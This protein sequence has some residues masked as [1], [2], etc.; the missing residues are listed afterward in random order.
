MYGA[1]KCSSGSLGCISVYF[2]LW[3]INIYARPVAT[4]CWYTI[5]FFGWSMV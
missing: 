4:P 1:I 5:C 3:I 2:G